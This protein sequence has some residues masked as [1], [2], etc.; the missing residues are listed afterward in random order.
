MAQP[1]P[2]DLLTSTDASEIIGQRIEPFV[3]NG[4]IKPFKRAGRN[5]RS[6]LLFLR[7]DV[8]K[9]VEDLRAELAAK[10]ERLQPTNSTA[11]ETTT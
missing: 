4:R 3:R 6:P 8:N 1:N 9:L 10:M 7:T 2:D 5:A 11:T